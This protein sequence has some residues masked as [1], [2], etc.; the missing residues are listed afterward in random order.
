M[1]KRLLAEV[2]DWIWRVQADPGWIDALTNNAGIIRDNRTT[3]V[4]AGRGRALLGRE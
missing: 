3:D 1:F 4:V 2:D